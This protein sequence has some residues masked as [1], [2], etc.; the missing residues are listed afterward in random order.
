MCRLRSDRLISDIEWY[1]AHVQTLI[2]RST[3]Y[4]R[5]LDHLYRA[6]SALGFRDAIL[7]LN[8]LFSRRLH[9]R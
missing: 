5:H 7:R 1:F 2:L 9:L 3:S 8:P 4:E 6:G